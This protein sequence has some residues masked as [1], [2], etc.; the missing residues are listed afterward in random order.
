MNKLLPLIKAVPVIIAC[1]LLFETALAQTLTVKGIVR[2]KDDNSLMPGVNIV[3]KGSTL[4]TTTDANGAYGISVSRNEVL[5]FSFIGYAS[6]E[7]T[8]S[9]QTEINVMLEPAVELLSD[10]VVVGYSEKKKQEITGSVVNVSSDKLKGV[11]GSNLEYLLQGK[12]AGVQVTTATGAPGAASEIRIRGN[13]SVN[14]DRGPLIVVDG[15]IGG[16]YNPN[17]IESITVLKDAGAIALYGSRANSGVI[18]VTT[19]KGTSEKPEITY[20][21]T[22]GLRNI[23]TGKFGIMDASELY[24]TERAM[25]ASSAQFNALRPASVKET[26]TDWLGLAYK[27]GVIQNHNVAASGRSGKVSYYLAGD[28]YNEQ[29]TLLTTDYE[30]F[31]LRSNLNFEVSKKVKLTTN[32]N[33]TRDVNNSYHWRWPYQ[34]F[35]YLPYDSPYGSDGSIRYVDATTTDFLTRDKN[36]ILHSAIYND[37]KTKGFTVNGDIILS[38]QVN[39]WLTV[40][41]RNRVGYAGYRNDSYEDSRTIEGSANNGVLSFGV[42]E[43]VSLI[44][45]NLIKLNKE[46]GLHS[47]GGFIGFE[48]QQYTAETAGASGYGIVSGIKIPGAVANPQD[49]SGNTLQ[50][51]ALSVLSEVNYDYKERYF[52]T[53]SFRRDGSSIFGANKRW[54]NFWALSGSWLVSKEDFFSSL[55]KSISFLKLRASYGVIGNDNIPAFQYLA[56]YNFTT[57]Y[58]GGSAGYPETLP[59]ADLGWE[60]TKTGNVGIDLTLFN[61]IDVNLDAFY[62]DT[63]QLLLKVQLPPSQG[64]AEV[65]KNAGRIVNQGVEVGISGDVLTQGKFKWNVSFNVGSARNTVKALAV[66]TTA[67]NK[68]YDG[69]KQSVQVGQD[70]NSWYLPKWVGVNET[71]GDPQWERAVL[72][73]NGNIIGYEVTNIYSDASSTNSLQFVGSATPKFFG[74]LN[75]AFTYERFTLTVSSSFQYGNMVYHRTRE[76]IDAD[77]ANFNFNLMQLADGWSRWQTA[78]DKTTHPKPVYGGNLQSNKPSSRFLEDGSFWRIRNITLNYNLPNDWLRKVKMTQANLFVSADNLFT[79]TKF[80]GLDPESPSFGIAGM[81]DFKYPISKQYLFGIQISF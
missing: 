19:K 77:G 3:V 15:I 76:F 52:L 43:G 60:Q 50:T 28:Y 70:I 51:R 26:N 29:G 36:N 11:T 25:F 47:I 48:G 35:L 41:S 39:S 37:Y 38:A 21:A 24:D 44:S 2:S 9:T 1:C 6:Q 72:D 5:I 8:V 49:I 79:F 31:N 80:S 27:Q 56:K 73:A 57:Q 33:I 18:V 7:I 78:G 53:G 30:R 54:G 66:G 63:D 17:D 12:V 45:T 61:K 46:M 59:N 65:F 64:I 13:S 20:R 74:G 67:V 69:V 14:A 32:L 55:N 81:N 71:N 23:T 22:V 75:S 62:K 42:S 40:Q 34:P 10:V 16:S 68:D 4:G 58:N